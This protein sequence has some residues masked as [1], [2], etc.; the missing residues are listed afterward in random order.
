MYACLCSVVWRGPGGADQRRDRAPP[1]R[2]TAAERRGALEERTEGRAG[3]S[4]GIYT[5]VT[6][7]SALIR[8]RL[9]AGGE[10]RV[11]FLNFWD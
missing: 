4:E 2:Q 1:R 6:P 7:D 8:S 5:G 9:P 10:L 11:Y 3:A